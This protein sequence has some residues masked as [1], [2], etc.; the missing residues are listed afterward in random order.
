MLTLVGTLRAADPVPLA[1]PNGQT[2]LLRGQAPPSE[3]LLIVLNGRPVG[4]GVS[5]RSGAYSLP[6]RAN[7]RPGAYSVEVR[8]RG[9]GAVVGR[10]TCLVDVPTDTTSNSTP[11]PPAARPTA[12]GATS[13]RPVVSPTPIPSATAGLTPTGLATVTPAATT[14]V[15]TGTAP[16]ATASTTTTASTPTPTPRPN[17]LQIEEIVLRDPGAP[18]QPVEYVRIYNASD[19]PI[20]IKDW[21]VL[22]VSRGDT[23]PPFVFPTFIIEPDQAI[24]VFSAVGDANLETGDFYW[25]LTDIW[26]VGD[27]A[28]LRDATD[29]LISFLVVSED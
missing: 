20:N 25:D 18:N 11:T 28:E 4:G 23:I 22:N 21:Q 9:S 15:G 24:G 19:R 7:E 16:T 2:V 27:R 6:L 12:P 14:T 10:F 17:D 13:T 29:R 8:L 3:A 5:D 1:C 26:R